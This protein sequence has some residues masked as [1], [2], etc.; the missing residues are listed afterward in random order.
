MKILL[1]IGAIIIDLLLAASVVFG[2][3]LGL[4]QPAHASALLAHAAVGLVAAGASML[5]A[6]VALF[7]ARKPA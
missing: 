3:W 5:A 1:W 7:M 4:H 2:L 6:L